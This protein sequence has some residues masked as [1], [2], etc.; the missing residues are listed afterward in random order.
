MVAQAWKSSGHP[1]AVHLVVTRRCNLSCSYC[2]EFDSHS[3]PVPLELLERRVDQLAKMGCT[4]IT[5]SGGEPLLHPHLEEVI[6]RIR[7][8]GIIA[9][10][11]TNGT[12]LNEQKIVSLNRAGL[13][14]L[15]ISIDQIRPDGNSRKALQVLSSKLDCLARH[16][17]FEVNINTVIGGPLVS[18]G[19]AL[20][21]AQRARGL[22]FS[23]TVGLV[24]NGNGEAI[25]LTETEQN[26]H[27]QLL[28]LS[29]PFYSFTR[30]DRFQENLA[31][32]LPNTWHCRAGARYMYICE[33]GL[34]H[35]CSQ[36]RG[37]PGI[38]LEQYT[39]EDA[40]RE[41]DTRK[42]C[43]PYCTISCVH[44]V[45]ALDQFREDPHGALVQLSAAYGQGNGLRS[46]PVPVR[47]LRWM[48]LSGPWHKALRKLALRFFQSP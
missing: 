16:A 28:N 33:D 43:S 48:F 41:G 37:H 2:N 3:A 1:I 45:A 30:Y 34:V 24:H 25:P 32:G 20:V 18:S 6:R 29:K 42:S 39:A 26:I 35:W 31:R 27:R 46:L 15:Q 7:A 21:I 5:L 17:L 11:L 12:L 8:N 22:G 44:Q 10:I 9:T 40:K 36:Q 4:V 23:S 14:R 13:D 19:D 47:I 38:P